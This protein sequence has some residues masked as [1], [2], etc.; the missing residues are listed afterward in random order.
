M[1]V[2]EPN[3]RW[4]HGPETLPKRVRNR[5]ALD[6]AL[7]RVRAHHN[8]THMAQESSAHADFHHRVSAKRSPGLP[9]DPCASI[10]GLDGRLFRI[11]RLI[12]GARFFIACL[13]ILGVAAI[14]IIRPGFAFAPGT[15]V[16]ASTSPAVGQGR[17]PVPVV[18]M[19]PMGVPRPIVSYDSQASALE[20]RAR[21]KGWITQVKHVIFSKQPESDPWVILYRHPSRLGAWRHHYL[22]GSVE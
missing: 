3:V 7:Q 12:E 18:V 14:V 5:T 15:P 16:E 4:N 8:P 10:P 9:L 6:I 11:E 22:D 13:A 21:V 2:S 1:N 17:A 20:A 19:S